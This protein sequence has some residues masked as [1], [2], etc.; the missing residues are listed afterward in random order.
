MV[1]AGALH[2]GPLLW[3]GARV[4]DLRLLRRP[5]LPRELLRWQ[6]R[7]RKQTAYQILMKKLLLLERTLTTWSRMTLEPFTLVGQCLWMVQ[8]F[9]KRLSRFRLVGSQVVVRRQVARPLV[10]QVVGR[11]QVARPLSPL[12]L[13]SKRPLW[14]RQPRQ[15]L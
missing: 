14:S 13:G 5:R 10:R 15:L 4:R 11:R 12:P 8:W 6:Q 7:L 9:P 1:V 3:D 2:Q